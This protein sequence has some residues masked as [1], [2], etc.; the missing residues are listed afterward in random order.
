MFTL[1]NLTEE[2]YVNLQSDRFVYIVAGLE[3]G[4][5]GTTVHLQGY[6]R[7]K[8]AKSLSAAK[9]CFDNK[10]H[11]DVR[12]G[13]I[14]QAIA[15]CKKDEEL[16]YL[17]KEVVPDMDKAIYEYGTKP[18]S[19]DE[20]GTKGK[21]YWLANVK[22]VAD[23]DY[24]ACDTECLVR[25]F[26][27]LHKVA[28]V[29]YPPKF[30]NL[31][32]KH[33]WYYGDPKSGKS[34]KARLEHPGAYIKKSSNKWWDGYK[35]QEVV[36]IEEMD[37]SHHY[38][39]GNLKEWCDIYPFTCEFKGGTSIIRPELIIITSNHHPDQIF[40]AE[41][42]SD[43]DRKAICRRFDFEWFPHDPLYETKPPKVYEINRQYKCNQI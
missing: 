43:L 8:D 23:H 18:L 3:Y 5:E 41:K 42:Q 17:T 35:G 24:H 32:T 9:K 12:R 39:L 38:Q 14:E 10:V 33:K 13:S 16:Y 22:A 36:I 20:K 40:T 11:L 25:N 31:T 1:H 29:L 15:Y 28:A 19:Q 2:D 34:E 21:E 30:E 6:C 37:C 4:S 27:A 26:E 7:F